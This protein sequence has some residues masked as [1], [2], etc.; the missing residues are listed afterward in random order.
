[1]FMTWF[2]K[3]LNFIELNLFIIIQIVYIKSDLEAY[4]IKCNFQDP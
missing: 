4:G 3:F 1:M 2:W